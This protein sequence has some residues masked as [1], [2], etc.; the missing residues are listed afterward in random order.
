MGRCTK[1]GPHG[2]VKWSFLKTLLLQALQLLKLPDSDSRID[3]R[4]SP[5]K[6]ASTNITPA[7]FY[8]CSLTFFFACCYF[9]LFHFGSQVKS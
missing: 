1:R 3:T 5:S 6:Q 9:D 8:L 2:Q 7:H 4:V